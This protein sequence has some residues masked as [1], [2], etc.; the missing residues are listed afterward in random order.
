MRARMI[1][2]M[3]KANREENKNLVERWTNPDL[4]AYLMN[5]MAKRKEN[6]KKSENTKPRL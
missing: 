2:P 5:Y 1:E 4:P 3:L 6:K